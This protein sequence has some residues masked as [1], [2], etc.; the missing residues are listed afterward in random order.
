M[1]GKALAKFLAVIALIFAAF[2]YFIGPLAQSIKQGLDLQGGTHIV[3]EAEDAGENKV[4]DDAVERARQILER[5]I[6]EMGLAEPLIQ[7]EGKKRIIIELPGVKDPDQAIK[8]IG[9]TAVM[10]FKDENGVVHLTGNDLKD[11]KEQIGQ[12]KQFMVAIEFTDEGAKKF[13]D[14]TTQNVGRHIGIYLDGEQLTNPV[15]NEP[16]TG[17]KA[18]ITG[19]K[20]LDEAKNLAILLRSGALPVKVNVLEVRTVGPTLGQDSKDKSVTAFAVGIG[21]I[22]AFML[23]LY[24]VSGFVATTALLIYVLLLLAVLHFLQ[25]TLT[26]PG[27][28]GIILSMG[29]AVD[30]NILIFER[31]KEEVQI[32]K[33]LR[34]SMESGFRRA[35]ATIV[36][37]NMSVMITAAI[38]FILGSG[39]VRGFAITLGLGVAISMVT[40]VF[41]SR[42][43]LRMLIEC[44]L[45]NHPFWYGANVSPTAT[46][47]LYKKGGKK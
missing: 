19:S 21:L 11:A 40:A 43:L 20:T 17:G 29:V 47:E 4:T 42:Y 1:N 22:V 36:D 30:A 37:A 16:I 32:G 2:I 7:R 38:L 28:A 6:N 46:M 18:V 9:K 27:I 15:V 39:P 34:M 8:T 41:V 12:N 35:L 31:F 24:R 33:T 5:R 13:A 3:L 25:A 45:T 44:N 23:V 26:L 14:L 10:E